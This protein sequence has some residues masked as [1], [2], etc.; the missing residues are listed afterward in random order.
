MS[1]RILDDIIDEILYT[2]FTYDEI[3]SDYNCPA[4]LD[5]LSDERK[6]FEQSIFLCLDCGFWCKRCDESVIFDICE[7]CYAESA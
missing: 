7:G 1:D 6:Y 2:D 5:P 4:F 3:A